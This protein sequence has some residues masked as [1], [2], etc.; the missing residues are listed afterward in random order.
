MT[1]I[2]ASYA[3]LLVAHVV[4][5]VWYY[6]YLKR[7]ASVRRQDLVRSFLGPS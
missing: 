1:T 4:E 2:K 3:F 6:F 5:A 7:E